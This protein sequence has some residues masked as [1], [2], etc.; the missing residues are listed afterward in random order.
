MPTFRGKLANAMLGHEM[1]EI[2]SDL[3]H[4]LAAVLAESEPSVRDRM[5]EEACAALIPD[6]KLS[7]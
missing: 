3:V 6:D 2:A 4:A 7:S 1:S 5:I